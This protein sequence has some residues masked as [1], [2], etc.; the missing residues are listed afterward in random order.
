MAKYLAVILVAV[1]LI[2]TIQVRHTHGQRPANTIS[3]THLI[4]V[5]V[6]ESLA[7]PQGGN[8]E[9]SGGVGMGASAAGG[10]GGG[11]GNRGQGPPGGMPGGGMPQMPGGGGNG[12]GGNN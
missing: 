9:V 10:G 2:A 3:T 1:L 8:M 12:G 4:R 6:Q 5:Q 7:L 11:P